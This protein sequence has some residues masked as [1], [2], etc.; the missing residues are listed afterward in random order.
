MTPRNQ[1]PYARE[2]AEQA[3]APGQFC[4]PY[5]GAVQDYDDTRQTT[6][7]GQGRGPLRGEWWF[8]MRWHCNTCKR[9]N[10]ESDTSL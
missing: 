1:L 4:C 8:E 5:C 3:L 2:C 9:V 10:V 7:G 6:R